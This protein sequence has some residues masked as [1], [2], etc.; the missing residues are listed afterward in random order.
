MDGLLNKVRESHAQIVEDLL[1]ERVRQ[2]EKFGWNRNHHPAEWLMILGEEVGEVN[3]EGIN[4]TFST[5]EAKQLKAITDMRTEL[6]QVAAVAM[7]MIEDLDDHHLPIYKHLDN[8]ENTR[9]AHS[10]TTAK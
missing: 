9:N 7:A 6:V 10:S 3:E 4:Y 2:N 8:N 5:D 1:K